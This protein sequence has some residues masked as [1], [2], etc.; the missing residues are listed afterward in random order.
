MKTVETRPESAVGLP[1]PLCGHN[2]PLAVTRS[3][4]ASCPECGSF[5]DKD[6]LP[7]HA[8]YDRSYPER[9]SHFDPAIG[10]LKVR[11]LRY[12]MRKLG[13]RTAE[14]AV[15]EVGFGGGFCLSHL[16][17]T[18]RRVFGVEAIR[19][20]IE[21]AVQLGI[22]PDSLYQAGT[23]PTAL[24]EKVDLWIFQDS[25]EHLDD[26]GQF[27]MWMVKNSSARSKILLVAPNGGSLSEKI[28][29]RWWP[30]KVSDH[31]FHWSKKGLI[32]FF[33]RHGFIVGDSFFPGKYLSLRMV[34]A[35]VAVK[36]GGL[37]RMEPWLSR[38]P[39]RDCA[40]LFNVGEMGLLLRK[41]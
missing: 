5:W 19:E 9:R 20:N 12:W 23:L 8:T 31:R 4:K 7:D 6:F 3:Y 33:S 21:H 39:L 40:F 35:H 36:T 26:P 34:L 16:R 38:F 25:F 13:I 29:R 10:A 2:Q 18:S 37:K 24:V 28:L 14:L 22:D 30:H 32:D 17:T 1:P 27:L 11:T 15:C 41:R